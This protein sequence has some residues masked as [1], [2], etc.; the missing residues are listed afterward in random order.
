MRRGGKRRE[1]EKKERRG[2]EC[3]GGG[4]RWMRIVKGV[5]T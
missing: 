1:G 5:V 3:E 4:G 2:F